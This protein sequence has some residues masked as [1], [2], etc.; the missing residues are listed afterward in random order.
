MLTR[1]SFTFE[2]IKDNDDD[3]ND[4]DYNDDDDHNVHQR[5]YNTLCAINLLPPW[6][7]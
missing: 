4:N 5:S 6:I 1:I 2:I 7:D 3:D